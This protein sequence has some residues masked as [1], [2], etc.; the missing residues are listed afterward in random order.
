[1]LY[2]LVLLFQTLPLP[3]N[4]DEAGSHALLDRF[5]ELGGNFIDTANVYSAGASESYIGT[6]LQKYVKKDVI[7]SNSYA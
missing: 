4:T 5:A 2:T 1:M 7:L 6:W 3:G